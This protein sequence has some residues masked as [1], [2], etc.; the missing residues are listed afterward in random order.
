VIRILGGLCV[1]VG[2]FSLADDTNQRLQ[3]NK[4]AP[5]DPIGLGLEAFLP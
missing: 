4:F 5:P 3:W 2:H 1:F